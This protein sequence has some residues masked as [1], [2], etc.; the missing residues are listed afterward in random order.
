VQAKD[1]IL[2]TGCERKVVEEVREHL[3]HIPTAILPN[4]LIKEAV[5]ET[6]REEERRGGARAYT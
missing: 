2:D 6:M 3:P 1:L 4:T 5:T